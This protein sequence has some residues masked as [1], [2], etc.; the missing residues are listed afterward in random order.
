MQKI[1]LKIVYKF[2]LNRTNMKCIANKGKFFPIVSMMLILP[3]LFSCNPLKKMQKNIDQVKI[4]V[5]DEVLEVHADSI[6]VFFDTYI[7][8][9]YFH[10]KAILKLEPV[11]IYNSDSIYMTPF[12]LAGEKVDLEANKINAKQVIP[13]ITGATVPY[14]E[15]LRYEPGMESSMLYILSSYKIDSKY[16]ELDQCICDVKKDK[17]SDGLIATS[18]TVQ[19]TDNLSIAGS[20]APERL[21]AKGTIYYECDKYVLKPGMTESKDFKLPFVISPV[22]DLIKKEGFQVEGMTLHSQASPDGP[23]Q[24]NEFLAKNRNSVSYDYMI[25]TLKTMNFQQVYDTNF[26][27]RGQTYEDWEGLK[28][29][30]SKSELSIKEDILKIIASELPLDEKEANIK[31]LGNWKDITTTIMPKLRKTEISL[32]AKTIIRDLDTLRKLYA[33]GKLDQFYNKQEVLYLAY[34][35]DDITKQEEL[36]NYFTTKYPE[37]ELVGKNNLAMIAIRKGDYDKALDILTPLNKKY[38]NQK[39]I[40]QNAGVC[41]RFKGQYDTALYL[42]DLAAK[43]GA[44]VKNNKAIVYIKK[45]E[46][47]MAIQT[48][49][50]NRYDYN[51]SL[52]YVL[53]KDYPKA[54]DVIDKVDNKTAQDFYLRAIIGARMK[55]VDLMTTSLTRAIKLDPSIRERAKVDREFRNY[56]DKP[57]FQN[58]LR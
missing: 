43:A 44:N 55:D 48:F 5:E 18:Q 12:L 34:N 49:E 30:I 40:L 24:R 54:K 10:K 37:D 22:L 4:K 31:K 11:L 6:N 23:L 9:K 33:E 47:D 20:F 46:Y 7:P 58:A 42:Y 39:E 14:K 50:E 2:N 52:A 3:F 17:L 36:Y 28:E 35:T 56:W 45:G 16:D 26:Y 1:Y 32:T 53:K 51:K 41:Y 21:V 19:P 13:Y 57:E 8:G 27:K 38:P 15:K 29:L 25:K